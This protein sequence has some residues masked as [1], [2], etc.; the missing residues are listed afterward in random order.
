MDVQNISGN[1]IVSN[2]ISTSTGIS[3]ENLKT[4]E[5]PVKDEIRIPEENKGKRIDIYA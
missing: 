1:D 5:E 3:N 4:R 2:R